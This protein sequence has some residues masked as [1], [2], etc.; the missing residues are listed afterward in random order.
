MVFRKC[1]QFH[2]LNLMRLRTRLYAIIENLL[3]IPGDQFGIDKIQTH[4]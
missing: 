3:A 2:F 4:D 1:D